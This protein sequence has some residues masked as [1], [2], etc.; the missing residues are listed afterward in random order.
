MTKNA[1]LLTFLLFGGTQSVQAQTFKV[2]DYVE[3]LSGATWMP[4]V[5]KTPLQ[6]NGYGVS[7]GATDYTAIAGPQYIRGRVPTDQ[8]HMTELE[9]ALALLKISSRAIDRFVD[10]GKPLPD[11]SPGTLYGTREPV[12]CAERTAPAHGAPSA[13][14][15]KQYVIC[16]SEHVFGSSLFLVANVKVQVAPVS[17]PPNG[18]V[19]MN[20][21]GIN[22]G[23]PVWDIRGSLTQYQCSRTG[24][25]DNDFA[26][27]HN[28]NIINQPAATGYCY[29]NTFGDWHCVMSDP[30]HTGAPMP[31]QLPPDG[32]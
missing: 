10:G 13:E 12:T 7:C 5:V 22:P 25:T 8:E 17:H 23:Q 4:C 15:A 21:A 32:N 9:T 3:M 31:Y 19:I 16:D 2:G 27:T 28:C 14:Q 24:A 30:Q 20:A 18:I 6:L 1:V 29:K 11:D 26:R